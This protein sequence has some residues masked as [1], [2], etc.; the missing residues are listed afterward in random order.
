MFRIIHSHADHGLALLVLTFS[1]IWVI[2][3]SGGTI[4]ACRYCSV[5]LVA[6][7]IGFAGNL[8]TATRAW[9]YPGQHQAWHM[10]LSAVSFSKLVTWYLLMTI[11]YV[12]VSFVN[13]PQKYRRSQMDEECDQASGGVVGSPNR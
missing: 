2:S 12:M 8:G 4:A 1:K 11:S 13:K 6:V 7:F 9:I 5:F 3:A 10:F